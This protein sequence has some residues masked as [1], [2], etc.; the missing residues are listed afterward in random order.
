MGHCNT[1]SNHHVLE[2][3]AFSLELLLYSASHTVKYF[4]RARSQTIGV[5]ID[6]LFAT[7]VYDPSADAATRHPPSTMRSKDPQVLRG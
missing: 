7:F 2:D 6:D 4:L 3:V 5:T 1:K